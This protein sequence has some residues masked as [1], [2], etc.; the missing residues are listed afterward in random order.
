M[1]ERKQVYKRIGTFLSL[2]FGLTWSIDL[3]IF[4]LNPVSGTKEYEYYVLALLW[5]PA[6]AAL[7]TSKIH[8]RSLSALGLN[9]TPTPD[10][11]LSYLIP[12]MYSLPAY[13]IVW[14]LGLGHFYN[15]TTFDRLTQNLGFNHLPVPLATLGLILVLATFGW[16]SYGLTALGEEIGWRGLLVPE[17]IK[18]LPFWKTALI[19]GVV[20]SVWHYPAILFSDYNGGTPAWYSLLC[21][22]ATLIGISF[23]LAWLRLK[24]R[25]VWTSVIFHSSHNLFIIDLFDPLTEKTGIA[26]YLISEFGAVIALSS[27]LVGAFFYYLSTKTNLQS[28]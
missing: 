3:L 7:L 25:T 2:T 28:G 26:R 18:I 14:I 20:W 10:Y 1:E 6:I 23:P 4:F 5:S 21:F 8:H 9:W 11:P 17:L 12:L 24:S 27:L 13:L 19:S 15:Q 22:S 16:L